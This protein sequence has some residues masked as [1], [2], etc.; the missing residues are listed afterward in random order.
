MDDAAKRKIGGAVVLEELGQS[1][2]TAILERLIHLDWEHRAALEMQFAQFE[3]GLSKTA[4][5]AAL[6][7][8]V[9][10]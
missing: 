1:P 10:S 3:I 9:Q 6:N 8:G 4:Q 7:V 5:A 2:W